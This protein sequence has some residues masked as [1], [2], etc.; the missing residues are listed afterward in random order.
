MAEASLFTLDDGRIRL[1]DS[2]FVYLERMLDPGG[3]L[4][5]D[6]APRAYGLSPSGI[7]PSGV[8]VAAVAPGEAVWL[9]FQA[10]DR[11][12]PA[13]VRVRVDSQGPID[14][15]TGGPWDET[16]TD[17]PRNYLVCPPDSRLPG[18]RHATGYRP[19]GVGQRS[20]SPGIIERLS[21]ICCA[22]TLMLV[23]VELATPE[24][25]TRLTG[26]VPEP[27]DPDSAYKGWRLP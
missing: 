5:E 17:E 25:F 1:D 8:V 24:V 3:P 6:V 18:V 22:D 19:F 2:V 4:P 9:G 7:A 14:A 21:V 11:A 23:P 16:L 13:I 27:L 26:L 10:I 12:Q 15:V 20:A